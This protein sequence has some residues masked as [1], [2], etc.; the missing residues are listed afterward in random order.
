M[1]ILVH[2]KAPP[3]HGFYQNGARAPFWLTPVY[4]K[5]GLVISYPLFNCLLHPCVGFL[6]SRAPSLPKLVLHRFSFAG[7]DSLYKT[8]EFG[9][10]VV[11]SAYW[12]IEFFRDD[13]VVILAIH[14]VGNPLHDE[15]HLRRGRQRN[16]RMLKD[17]LESAVDRTF[18]TLYKVLASIH[19]NA[20]PHFA[21]GYQ[22]LPSFE[23]L[24]PTPP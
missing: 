1:L 5:A 19:S 4:P 23:V 3:H 14:R 22:V 11:R 24:A 2:P 16:A 6:F 12:R 20:S 10:V 17:C 21:L 15:N 9:C 18:L 13:V 7:A 8:I